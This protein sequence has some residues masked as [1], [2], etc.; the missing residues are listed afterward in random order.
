[1]AVSR[2]AEQAAEQPLSQ[3]YILTSAAK[4]AT[5]KRT[6]Y[7]SAEALRHPKSHRLFPQR[8]KQQVVD[9]PSGT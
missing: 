3:T 9:R 5:E 4:A 6:A 7:R 1:V 8:V 2:A